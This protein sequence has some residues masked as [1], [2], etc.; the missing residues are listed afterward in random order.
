MAINQALQNA[1]T[2]GYDAQGIA[3]GVARIGALNANRDASQSRNAL[4]QF[5]LSR[6]PA[7]EQRAQNQDARLQGEF[8]SQQEEDHAR[9]MYGRLFRI[10]TLIGQGDMEGARAENENFRD[11]ALRENG[12]RTLAIDG[13]QP[14]DQ[15][16]V[17]E[18]MKNMDDLIAEGFTRTG[19]DGKPLLEAPTGP[20]GNPFKYEREDGSIGL[21]RNDANGGITDTGFNAP[22]STPLVTNTVSTG[23]LG[24]KAEAE[25]FAKLRVKNFGAITERAI[26]AEDR[27]GQ[28]S[29]MRNIDI[30][31]NPGE[32]MK[33]QFREFGAMLGL[34][35]DM[36]KITDVQSFAGLSG[37]MVL[38]IMATQKGPQTDNDRKAIAKT[39]ASVNNTPDANEF[40]LDSMEALA[41]RQIEMDSFYQGWI[42]NEGTLK[43]AKRAW[44]L[45]K[46]STP[47]VSDNVKD[48]ETGLPI[49]FFDYKQ[50]MKELNPGATDEQIIEQW[51]SDST[52]A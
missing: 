32:A 10:R 21:G 20:S 42:D 49:F 15:A 17:D 18:A 50:T 33:N 41:L 46:N 1:V 38:D 47:M 8:E 5:N 29:Q 2:Q 25:A 3:T 28:I 36:S 7:V 40:L 22:P 31:T 45:F 24:D 23:G 19:R 11:P 39:T 44:G 4:S 14:D 13:S 48:P 51:R 43:G 37:K 16:L 52:G 12:R 34:P 6:G 30:D 9:E 35:V 27:L 26:A